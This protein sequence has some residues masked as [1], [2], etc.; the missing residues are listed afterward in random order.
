MAQSNLSGPLAITGALTVGGA[1][2]ITGNTQI[3]G[4]LTVGGQSVAPVTAASA[5]GAITIAAGVVAITK[6]S[7]CAMTLAD[8]TAVTHDGVIMEFISTTA[9]AHTLSN[10]AG[11][12]F[13][14]G[15][16]ASDIGT[17]GAAVGNSI[18]VV[19]YNGKWYV[20]NNVNVTLA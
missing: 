10:S 5:D 17:F 20:L 9:Y 12:G 3:T 15:G 7:A 18:R 13:N 8:P 16:A 11:S 1:A 4:S 14:G 19:A 6:G 2:T